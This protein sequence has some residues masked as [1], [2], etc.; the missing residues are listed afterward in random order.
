MSGPPGRTFGDEL[1][2]GWGSLRAGCGVWLELA[3]CGVGQLGDCLPELGVGETGH[4][5]RRVRRRR[6]RWCVGHRWAVSERCRP[7]TQT[8]VT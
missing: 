6:L 5:R 8:R 4:V 2:L 1:T 3:C 7:S